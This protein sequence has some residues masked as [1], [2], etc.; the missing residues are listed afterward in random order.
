MTS[1]FRSLRIVRDESPASEPPAREPDASIPDA[2]VSR[3]LSDLLARFDAFIRRTASRHGLAGQDVDDV[4]QDLRVRV[5]KSFGTAELIRR[6]KP[7]Y[8]YR[9]AVSASLDIIRRRRAVK[10]SATAL[11][12]VHPSA[13]VDDRA[14]ADAR[15]AASELGRAV[16]EA[17]GMLAESR[18]GVVRMY[19]SGYDR[20]EIADLLGWTE[21]KTRNLLYRG[22]DDLRHVLASRGITRESL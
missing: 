22:L 17:L 19:L 20:F 11:D 5:W 16:H 21:G 7:T 4:V 15:L 2:E 9:V 3:A 10:S 6:A 1:P 14:S 18:R 13:L 12:D 8:M